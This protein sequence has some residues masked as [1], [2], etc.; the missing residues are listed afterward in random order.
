M[1]VLRGAGLV[2][3]YQEPAWQCVHCAKKKERRLNA[4]PL[5]RQNLQKHYR[6]NAS[7]PLSILTLTRLRKL[8]PISICPLM[9]IETRTSRISM[10]DMD[11]SGTVTL[12]VLMMPLAVWPRPVAAGNW[13]CR[14]A[15]P[16][17]PY[18][19]LLASHRQDQERTEVD[20]LMNFFTR[21]K[22]E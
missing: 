10:P 15:A 2:L 7:R 8:M 18:R 5:A 3:L 16:F 21:L 13:Q 19:K 6:D 20:K 9:P 22:Y 11:R 14:T 4:T 1:I 17:P 12:R